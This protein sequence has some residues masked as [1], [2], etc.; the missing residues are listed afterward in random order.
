MN[1]KKVIGIFIVCIGSTFSQVNAQ[2]ICFSDIQNHWAKEYIV[3]LTEK[4]IVSGYEDNTFKPEDNVTFAEFIKMIVEAGE[5]TIVR[6]GNAIYPDFYIATA[7]RQNIIQTMDEKNINKPLT[8]YEMSE[9]VA[10]FINLKDTKASRNIFKDVNDIEK[11]KLENVLKLVKLGVING[12]TDKTFK[13]SNNV[14]RAEAAKVIL[15]SISVRDNLVSKRTYNVEE[16]KE[17]SN[18]LKEKSNLL[19]TFYE[20]SN[21]SLKIY[22]YG[23]YSYLEGYEVSNIQI[24]IDKVIKIIKKL[25]NENAYVAV[26][27]VPSKYTIN[28]LKILYGANR[29]KVLYGEYD[30][31]FNYYENAMYNLANKSMHEEFSNDCYLRIDVLKLWDDYSEYKNGIYVNEYKKEKLNEALKAEFGTSST[32]ISKYIIDKS[33]SY[34]TN[35]T[36]TEEIAEKKVIGKYIVN[37]YKKVEGFP[38]FYI[39]RK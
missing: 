16:E 23:R 2:E 3:K 13:G 15:N 31:S 22:D 8:R 10:N 9:I 39:E 33:V 20:I 35:S 26:I 37:Y 5:Y 38:Q 36:T 12:Y 34:V 27:Y 18:Y 19:E 1:F 30:F 29:N 28:E 21:D 14:T 24:D 17:L 4:E 25:I 7:Q 11:D 6:E 32:K